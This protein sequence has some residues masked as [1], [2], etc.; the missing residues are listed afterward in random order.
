MVDMGINGNRPFMA[1]VAK[2]PVSQESPS[3]ST[4]SSATSSTTFSGTIQVSQLDGS[5]ITV[6]ISSATTI[7]ELKILIEKQTKCDPDKQRLVFNK[8]ELKVANPPPP[9]P[10][11][12]KRKFIYFSS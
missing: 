4:S 12:K 9:L 6:N 3:P 1:S 2:P 11:Q 8:Q 5:S 7:P 10:P